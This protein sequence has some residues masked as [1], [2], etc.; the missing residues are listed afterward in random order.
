MALLLRSRSPCRR[1]PASSDI[2]RDPHSAPARAIPRGPTWGVADCRAAGGAHWASAVTDG[3]ELCSWDRC[4]LDVAWL[5]W[6]V[7]LLWGGDS[8]IHGVPCLSLGCPAWHCSRL[9]NPPHLQAHGGGAWNPPALPPG[10]SPGS[11]PPD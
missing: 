5:P 7:V 6:P 3:S 4:I 1:A 9:R 2:R 10:L 11:D 8:H